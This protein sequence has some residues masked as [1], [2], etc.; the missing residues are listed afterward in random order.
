MIQ[1]LTAYVNVIL[2]KN[3]SVLL[4][5]R[6]NTGWMDGFWAL[7]GGNL[8]HGETPFNAII[9]ETDEELGILLREDKL[10]FVHILHHQQDTSYK[11]GFYFA[12]SKWYGEPVNNEPDKHSHV[13]WHALDA[14]P[15]NILLTSLQAL[16]NYRQGQA[17]SEFISNNYKINLKQATQYESPREL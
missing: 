13:S 11:I 14:L 15:E 3:N 1:A 17:Y 7:P 4:V 2:I 5:H 16:E 6:S 10:E 9:R 8:D 12:C